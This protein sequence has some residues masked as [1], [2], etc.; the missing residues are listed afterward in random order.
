ML[1]HAADGRWVLWAD[2]DH[3][4]PGQQ[5]QHPNTTYK[6]TNFFASP[7]SSSLSSSLAFRAV[8][9]FSFQK[10][11]RSFCFC[12]CFGFGFNGAEGSS[13]RGFLDHTQEHGF[14]DRGRCLTRHVELNTAHNTLALREA[15]PALPQCGARV[16]LLVRS[17]IG[18][19]H[20]KRIC[21]IDEYMLRLYKVQ[22]N[23]NNNNNNSKKKSV[24]NERPH[25]TFFLF[26]LAVRLS[27]SSSSSKG[28]HDHIIHVS[29]PPHTSWYLFKSSK[30]GYQNIVR[31]W[32]NALVQASRYWSLVTKKS[33]LQLISF[34]CF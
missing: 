25:K 12:F 4:L 20:K 34:Y 19:F 14:V 13:L 1:F 10:K 11:K 8:G 30:A 5:L 32:G 27:R 6:Q 15:K 16:E 22:D 21:E 33:T 29:R 3:T 18:L 31:E 17:P 2:C 7:S 9:Q 28:E 26:E 24:E 23:N